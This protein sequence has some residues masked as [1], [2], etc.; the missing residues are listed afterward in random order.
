MMNAI[1]W[2]KQK[3]TEISYEEFLI[4]ECI[5]CVGNDENLIKI[6]MTSV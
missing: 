1:K 2:H 5:V 6:R 4:V 3:T